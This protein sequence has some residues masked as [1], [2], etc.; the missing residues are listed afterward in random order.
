MMNVLLNVS[1]RSD[2]GDHAA[3]LRADEDR[4]RVIDILKQ[5]TDEENPGFLT[6]EMNHLHTDDSRQLLVALQRGVRNA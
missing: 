3:L 5:Q 4:S 1:D 2:L 6:R